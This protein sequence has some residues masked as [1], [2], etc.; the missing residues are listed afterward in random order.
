MEKQTLTRVTQEQMEE[1][2]RGDLEL[3]RI[4]VDVEIGRVA[5]LI[6]AGPWPF[7]PTSG[8]EP[9]WTGSSRQPRR[10]SGASTSW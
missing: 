2:H 7:R 9:T 5:V 4:Y 6:G 3:A 10:S 1:Q 8:G